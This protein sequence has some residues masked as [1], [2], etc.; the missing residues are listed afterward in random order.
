MSTRE[1]GAGVTT[2]AGSAVSDGPSVGTHA[3]RI[4]G[5]ER[6]TGTQQFVADIRL[7]GMLHVK[8]VTLD[9]GRARI[10]SIDASAALALPGVVDVLTPADLPQ[11]VPRFGP[12]YQDRPVLA[13][14]ETS[15]HGEPVAAVA[16]ETEAI[17]EQAVA[18]VRVEF[19]EL[20]AV[21]TVEAAL[22]DGAPLVQA[23]HVRPAGDP[24][25]HTNVLKER[26]YGW[27]DVDEAERGADVVVEN[28]YRF[29]MVTHFA[30]EPHGF[31]ADV[32]PDDGIRLWSPVQHPYLLQ[33]MMADLFDR[34][35][36]Q[37]RV[38]AP[39][40]GGGFGGKQNPKLE[41]VL[42]HL[43]M[44]TGRPC[45]LI[46]TLEE[47]FQAVRRAATRVHVRTGFTREG[48]LVFQDLDAE[49]LIGAYADIAERVM[50]KSAYLA[51]GPYR[52]PTARIRG[53]AVL[54]HTTP[55]TAFRGFGTPQMNWA[56]ES[57]MDAGARALGL[58][59]LQIRMLNLA[60][61]GD[62]VVKDD[63]PA[64]GDWPETLRRAADLLGW[65]TP[66]PPGRGRGIAVGIKSGATTGLSN[67]TVRLLAD[68]SVIVYAGT[69]DMG[70]GARTIYAQLAADQL[71]A[72]LE[73]VTVVMGDTAVVPFDLQTSASRSTVFM[74]TAITRACDDIHAQ[75]RELAADLRGVD[76]D[77]VRVEGGTVHLPGESLPIT[78][79]V[80]VGLGRWNGEL[81]GN[82]RMR[83]PHM[84]D[85]PL[86][87]TPAFFEF[88]C[89][90]FEVEVDVETGEVLMHQHVTVSDVGKA[91]NPLQVEMQD[92][93]A[94]IM[95][96]GHSLMEHVIL[97]EHG[98][99]RNLGA[100]DYR[101]PTTKD[102]PLRLVTGMVENLDGPG[103]HGAKGVSEGALL[104]TAPALSAAVTDATGA[105]FTELPMTPERVWRAVRDQVQERVS[106]S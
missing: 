69:S 2:G 29:P 91:L 80:R 85:H 21:T 103:P 44:R 97:D 45:R 41:P 36:T 35:L 6:V 8:L 24:L 55:S 59:G 48:R 34:P 71:G 106:S 88:N 28:T 27:G 83:K 19:E 46:L 90:A 94:A 40:P 54:S 79:F 32:T 22:A 20:P 89:T 98:R 70:Q 31:I 3:R 52:V 25:A 78:A 62:E 47:T 86:G 73:K 7:E 11:P 67:A 64:D 14:G 23:P 84:A 100:L 18:L 104:C 4:G 96:L 9:V 92:E 13:D 56:V 1:G 65:N 12:A 26:H 105:V 49:Y 10:T 15:Y 57:Q 61:R 93:G 16:A 76:E 99:I 30:I 51:C 43:A 77:D 39:D 63:F 68:G 38:F 75:L 50:T 82:G 17:A 74:G 58:D 37:V 5:R 66:T 102:V 87:G 60:G 101:I 72:P 42:I 95:G 81:I 53:R 33:K